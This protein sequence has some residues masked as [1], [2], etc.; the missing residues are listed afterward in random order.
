MYSLDR[1]DEEAIRIVSHCHGPH[2]DFVFQRH[3]RNSMFL[4]PK[5]MYLYLFIYFGIQA[6][7]RPP[8]A[9]KITRY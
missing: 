9:R 4:L 3:I 7:V 5:L 1:V 2:K 6:S 8:F